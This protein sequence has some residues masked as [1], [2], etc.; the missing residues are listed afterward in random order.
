MKKAA[1]V[2]EVS[3]APNVSEV[4]E[5]SEAVPVWMQWVLALAA[6]GLGAWFGWVMF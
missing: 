6:L 5:V 3:E 2:S 4:P 1:R